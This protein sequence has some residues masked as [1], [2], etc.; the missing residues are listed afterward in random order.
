MKTPRKKA[1]ES[2]YSP[3]KGPILIAPPAPK[4][5]VPSMI[6]EPGRVGGSKRPLARREHPKA[7]D[8]TGKASREEIRHET[9]RRFPS[10][11]SPQQAKHV[12]KAPGSRAAK[13]KRSA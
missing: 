6:P 2:V 7:R 11:L 13:S 5:V 10:R 4:T 1:A 3:I 9:S 8:L 12:G